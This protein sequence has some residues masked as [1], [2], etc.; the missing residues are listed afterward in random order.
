MPTGPWVGL[1][2]AAELV[3]G[4]NSATDVAR[5]GGCEDETVCMMS[6]TAAIDVGSEIPADSVKTDCAVG[7]VEDGNGADDDV[8][9]DDGDDD[10][11]PVT[12]VS[13]L[14]ELVGAILAG[15]RVGAAA[16]CEETMAGSLDCK[17]ALAVDT[18]GAGAD[19]LTTAGGENVASDMRTSLPVPTAEDAAACDVGTGTG[20]TTDCS[21]GDDDA[22]GTGG[23][24]GGGGG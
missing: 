21:T 13:I 7:G 3:S 4:S 19:G 15:G 24:G 9:D 22:G 23:G 12:A 17:G 20:T 14:S 10:D 1:P 6:G 8:D 16:T 2:I 18:A 5:D 11:S